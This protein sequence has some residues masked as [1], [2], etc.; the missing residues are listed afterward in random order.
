MQARTGGLFRRSLP[1][2]QCVLG[3]DYG[4]QTIGVAAGY[5]RLGSAAGAGV[6]NVS[7]GKPDAQQIEKIFSRWDPGCCVVGMPMREDGT[8]GSLAAQIRA[9]AARLEKTFQCPVA[10]VDERLS[11]EEARH[12]LAAQGVRGAS[13][14]HLDRRHQM[15]AQIILETFFQTP[16]AG[17]ATSSSES[18]SSPYNAGG[19]PK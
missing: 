16:P 8:A 7:D 6:I 5:P 18:A 9:F 3:F 12:R 17:D 4:T 2:D 13:R 15:A 1:L 11:T 10:F 19:N 14:K